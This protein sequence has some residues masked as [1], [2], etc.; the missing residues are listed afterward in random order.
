MR[1]LTY[2]LHRDLSNDDLISRNLEVHMQARAAYE[3]LRLTSNSAKTQ[4][5]GRYVLRYAYGLLR[6][7]LGRTLREDELDRHP[8]ELLADWHLRLLVEV[9]REMGSTQPEAV[10]GEPRE[11]MTFPGFKTSADAQALHTTTSDG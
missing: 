4:E 2:E 3:Q 5:A 7:V 11:W 9:R 8:I 10:F 1:H 6:L